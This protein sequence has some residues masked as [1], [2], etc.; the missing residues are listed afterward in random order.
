MWSPNKHQR[1][2]LWVSES[3]LGACLKVIDTL[4]NVVIQIVT[5]KTGFLQNAA[6]IFL[7]CGIHIEAPYLNACR[8]CQQEGY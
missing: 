1:G 7:E 4:V 8:N 6:K 3:P 2:L 5:C